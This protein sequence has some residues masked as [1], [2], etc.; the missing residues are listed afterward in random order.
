MSTTKELPQSAE[1]FEK[2][3]NTVAV[4]PT[5]SELFD[6]D[7]VS[8]YLGTFLA[9]QVMIDPSVQ[10][11]VQAREVNSIIGDFNPLALNVFVISIRANGD[12]VLLD[13]QQRLNA[14]VAAGYELPMDAKFYTG[15]TH[16]EEAILF[17]QLNF[18]QKVSQIELFHVACVE[19]DPK[20]LAITKIL[21]E[22]GIKVGPSTGEFSAVS[23][24]QR[25][26]GWPNGHIAFTWAIE[27]ACMTWQADSGQQRLHGHVIEAL[28]MIYDRYHELPGAKNNTKLLDPDVMR[29]KLAASAN[30]VAGILGHA[31]TIRGY[32]G[33]RIQV[34]IVD[35]LI[36]VY[37]NGF[38]NDENK[39]PEWTR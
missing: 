29:K 20:A 36:G 17:R 10:R 7:R 16:Q 15:L 37:N 35:H 8:M 34:N 38:R 21:K 6:P 13:G 2:A 23:A 18:R 39:L 33:G 1:E 19:G 24:A 11:A 12:W 25:I 32:K 28:A 14:A 31:R 9:K 5:R 4:N 3:A 27:M 26:L 30:G 22:F